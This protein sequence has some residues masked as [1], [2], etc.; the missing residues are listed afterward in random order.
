MTAYTPITASRAAGADL[1]ATAL[2][3]PG[4]T[5]G[6]TFAPG[7]ENFLRVQTSGTPT[8]V[9]VIN[10]SA[11]AGP[12]GTFLAPVTLGGGAMAATADRLFGP[13]PASTF[14]D[15]SDGQVHVT[16]SSVTGVKVGLYQT[17]SS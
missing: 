15:P 16:Y 17:A 12:S 8:T 9:T 13:F 10:T 3:S 7:Y 1:T 5:T 6:D 2:I 4:G 11:N 14:A